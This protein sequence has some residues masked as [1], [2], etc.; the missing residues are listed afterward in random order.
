MNETLMVILLAG[1]VVSAVMCVI[2]RDL[3]KAAIALAM[4]SAILAI[5]MFMSNAHLAAVFELSVCAGLVTVVFISSISMTRLR[6]K[7]DI[8]EQERLRR[9]RFELLP[10][11]LIVILSVL[12]FAFWPRLSSVVPYSAAP[13][14]TVTEQ[15]LFWHTRQADLLGQL[16]AILA[17]V[18][19][20]LIFFKEREGD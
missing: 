1:L 14:E 17:G 18:F 20:V 10:V 2:I 12:L 5:I 6:T 9:R 15:D 3:L 19:G 7:E 4:V 16:V 8:A 11:L 13:P